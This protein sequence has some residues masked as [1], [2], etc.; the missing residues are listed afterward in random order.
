MNIDLNLAFTKGMF[1]LHGDRCEHLNCPIQDCFRSLNFFLN[2]RF[3]A[4]L[5]NVL[6]LIIPF[7]LRRVMYCLFSRP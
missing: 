2:R 7:F 5:A 3:P 4:R 1:D 6:D